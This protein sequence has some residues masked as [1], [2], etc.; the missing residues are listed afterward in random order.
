MYSED[1]K[2]YSLQTPINTTL[3]NRY[4]AFKNST[5]E[6]DN[7]IEKML[8]E[9]EGQ[10]TAIVDKVEKMKT[11][12]KDEKIVLAFFVAFQWTRTPSFKYMHSV[13]NEDM[14]KQLSKQ[15]SS[16]REFMKQSLKRVKEEHQEL[17][18]IS[19]EDMIEF[20]NSDRYS[21]SVPKE[22]YLESML[23][24]TPDFANIFMQMDW[25]FVHCPNDT[26]FI[27]SDAPFLIIPPENFDV[28]SFYGL[29]L[30][31]LG[32]CKMMPLSR[33]VLLLIRDKGNKR[34]H[35]KIPD[36]KWVKRVNLD[37]ANQSRNYVIAKDKPHLESLIGV[38]D[39]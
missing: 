37:I 1:T 35:S 9:L 18:D 28:K 7:T 12:T 27:T 26:S 25:D 38:I 13:L 22:M 36:R 31:T 6:I 39:K 19:L 34:T 24:M 15:I 2:E 4:Y 20:I 21:V 32:A 5:G 10:Y 23:Y 16:N 29:G 30:T 8:G 3:E 11:L 14:V 33:H 17:P